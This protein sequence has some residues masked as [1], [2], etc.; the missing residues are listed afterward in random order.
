[1][2][3]SLT[4]E[5]QVKRD[6]QTALERLYEFGELWP[7]RINSGE[8]RKGSHM[9]KLAREGSPDFIVCLRGMFVAIEIKKPEE[10]KLRASQER[11]KKRILACGGAWMTVNNID[12]FYSKL[13]QVRAGAKVL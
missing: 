7:I 12:E 13:G 10:T 11:E 5:G 4:P 2:S 1:M 8:V 9:V 6:I 3:K